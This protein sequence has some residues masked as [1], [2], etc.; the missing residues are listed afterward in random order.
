MA[1][2]GARQL[3]ALLALAG[4]LAG[5]GGSGA[6]GTRKPP[7]AAPSS[8]DTA[9]TAPTTTVPPSSRLDVTAVE[10]QYD[11]GGPVNLAA[12]EVTITLRN[13][14]Q[15]IHHAQLLRLHD[16]V[17]SDDVAAAGS[18]DP[19]AAPVLALGDEVGG[20]GMVSPGGTAQSTQFLT[21][22]SYLMFCLVRSPSGE[23][24]TADGMVAQFDVTS[25]RASHSV[26]RPT[27]ELRLTDSGFGLPSPFPRRG[28]LKVANRGHQPHEVTFLRLPT[29]RTEAAIQ[30]YLR[31]LQA[32]PLLQPPPPYRAAGGVAAVSPGETA[33][34]PVDLKPGTY[35]AICLVRGGDGRPHALHGMIKRFTVR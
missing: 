5:C 8:V 14:G 21:P 11:A 2:S 22:G 6:G 7:A 24:H 23:T 35:V 17:T 26:P 27:A 31:A 13:S 10:F 20:P 34:V 29:G 12:G 25:Q 4:C 19:S 9:T 32:S 30:P 16:G 1:G 18:N 33:I 3:L 15:E 28:V